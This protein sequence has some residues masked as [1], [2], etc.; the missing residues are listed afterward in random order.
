[1]SSIPTSGSMLLLFLYGFVHL[2]VRPEQTLL[3]SRK[4]RGRRL[5]LGLHGLI[6]GLVVADKDANV[7]LAVDSFQQRPD[8]RETNRII[9]HRHLSSTTAPVQVLHGLRN[10]VGPELVGSGDGLDVLDHQDAPRLDS[11]EPKEQGFRHLIVEVGSVVDDHHERG[12][13]VTLHFLGPD[14][15]Q[16][17]V[18]AGVP[19]VQ[20]IVRT[21]ILVPAVLLRKVSPGPLVLGAGSLGDAG[22]LHRVELGIRQK[23][24]VGLESFAIVVTNLQQLDGVSVRSR[25][26]ADPA[27]VHGVVEMTPSAA[28][29]AHGLWV[30][31]LFVVVEAGGKQ[32]VSFHLV[33]S[34]FS[35]HF[36]KVLLL[37]CNRDA[38]GGFYCWCGGRRRRSLLIVV[39]I[40]Q[41]I[42]GGNS[43][44]LG[45]KPY[46]QESKQSQK[47]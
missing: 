30:E 21:K 47:G 8:R 42:C 10:N 28:F 1:M 15:L 39:V 20:S 4:R 23:I 45:V 32:K 22:N 14:F 27:V 26:L 24:R 18:V 44:L 29:W 19:T 34:G 33:R 37:G 16:E 12:S 43:S 6:R 46:H 9:V 11:G 7:H 38:G 41:S 25:V 36:P 17:V 3:G 35:G 31:A 5:G 40:F 13:V 2:F